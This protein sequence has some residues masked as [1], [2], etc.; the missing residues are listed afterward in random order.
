MEIIATV[1]RRGDSL[2]IGQ[3]LGIFLIKPV[4]KK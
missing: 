1:K 4:G 2:G 3:K